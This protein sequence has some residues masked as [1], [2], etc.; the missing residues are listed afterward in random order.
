MDDIYKEKSREYCRQL[1][2][3]ALQ[4][5]ITHDVISER[6]N[7]KRSNVTRMLSGRYSPTLENFIKLCEAV[8]AT[9]TVK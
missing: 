4:K 9:I 6:T 3:I 5:K 7:F 1:A 2:A 8:D